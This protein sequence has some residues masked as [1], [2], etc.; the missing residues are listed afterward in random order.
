MK[1][2]ISLAAMC[3][4]AAC[5]NSPSP[6]ETSSTKNDTATSTGY[7][8]PGAAVELRYQWLAKP[9][10]GQTGKLKMEFVGAAVKNGLNVRVDAEPALQLAGGKKSLVLQHSKSQSLSVS[11]DVDV[12][13]IQDGKSYINVFVES[14]EGETKL[15]RAFAIPVVVGADTLKT[16]PANIVTQQDGSK[17]IELPAESR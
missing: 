17:V 15:G 16:E 5:S 1:S 3:V 6:T 11:N 10:V 13:V 12:A 7:Q 2:L 9:E 14:G 8:K 4:L